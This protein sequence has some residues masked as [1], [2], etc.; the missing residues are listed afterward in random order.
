MFLIFFLLFTGWSFEQ[1]WFFE[2]YGKLTR[3]QNDA[4]F[5]FNWVCSRW[6]ST[7]KFN[8]CKTKI[9]QRYCILIIL[10]FYWT[11]GFLS[12]LGYLFWCVLCSPSSSLPL[13]VNNGWSLL[14]NKLL[15]RFPIMQWPKFFLLKLN[16]AGP[17][18]NDK[19]FMHLSFY[20]TYFINFHTFEMWMFVK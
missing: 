6:L 5:N 19:N 11:R 15:W 2:K 12:S 13:R 10:F 17:I 3:S 18:Q 9:P 20:A 4:S 16:H 1:K 7:F 14:K 8:S